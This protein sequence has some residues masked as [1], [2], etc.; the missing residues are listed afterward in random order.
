MPP[1]RVPATEF[2][3]DGDDADR[4]AAQSRTQAERIMA[5]NAR[6]ASLDPDDG[7]AL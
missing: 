2:E 1:P 5:R 7:V 4:E 3:F 6:V